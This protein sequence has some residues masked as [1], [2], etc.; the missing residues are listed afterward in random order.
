MLGNM[1]V[2]IGI[3]FN[4]EDQIQVHRQILLI[5]VLGRN[6]KGFEFLTHWQKVTIDAPCIQ[7]SAV[8][9]ILSPKFY[10]HLSWKLFTNIVFWQDYLD[11]GIQ[12][13]FFHLPSCH[14][15]GTFDLK[16]YATITTFDTTIFIKPM[17]II[18]TMISY[19]CTM[20]YFKHD[21]LHVSVK[22]TCNT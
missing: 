8:W 2:F 6:S 12:R 5:V 14:N 10:Q 11:V 21:Q 3:V 4:I 13:Q 22:F 20:Y 1:D 9:N 17:A 16:C 19:S 7:N 15:S 18:C